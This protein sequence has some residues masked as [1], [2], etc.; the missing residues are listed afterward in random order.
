MFRS[1][2][3]HHQGAYDWSLAKVTVSL[4]SSFK[5]IIKIVGV[6]WQYEYQ[7][8]VCTLSAVRR[9][10]AG[11]DHQM[12]QIKQEPRIIQVV[13][14]DPLSKSRIKWCTL[15]YSILCKFH[16]LFSCC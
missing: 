9:V 1:L 10:T 15:Y 4:K 2:M 13:T 16:I 8:V 5:Y 14:V 7:V 12:C 11:C 6:R 3:D